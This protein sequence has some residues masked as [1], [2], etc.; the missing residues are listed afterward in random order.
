M[1]RALLEVRLIMTSEVM[2]Q[3]FDGHFDTTATQPKVGFWSNLFN[4]MILAREAEARRRVAGHLVN[5]SDDH[6]VSLGL[7]ARDIELARHGVNLDIAG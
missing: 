2:N 6:L 4:R 3:T 5:V 1:S 7:S